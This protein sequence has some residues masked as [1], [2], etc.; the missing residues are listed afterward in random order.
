VEAQELRYLPLQQPG[1]ASVAID[2][3]KQVAYI[4][5]LGK[6]GDG[7]TITISSNGMEVGLFDYLEQQEVKRLIVICSHPHSDHV[8]G[9]EAAFSSSETFIRADGTARFDQIDVIDDGISLNNRL[10][11][12][13]KNAL[14]LHSQIKVNHSSAHLRNALSGIS[15][16]SDDIFIETIPYEA[17]PNAGTHG[18][19][20]VTRIVLGGKQSVVDFDDADS[21]VIGKV[22]AQ[23]KKDKITKIDAFVV[24]HH[25][26]AYHDISPIME[27][28][29]AIAI[30]AVNPANKYGHPAAPILRAL[31]GKLKLENVI[32][33]GSDGYV[34]IGPNGVRHSEHTAA[35]PES[36]A[37][38]VDPSR[39]RAERMG[40]TKDLLDYIYIQT[41]MMKGEDPPF[42]GASSNP[43]TPSGPGPEGTVNGTG[44]GS[45]RPPDSPKG[46]A[47]PPV[48]GAGPAQPKPLPVAQS[49]LK[50]AA[51]KK[52]RSNGTAMSEEFDVGDIAAGGIRPGALKD[53]KLFGLPAA[54]LESPLTVW[55]S[56]DDDERG[57]SSTGLPQSEAIEIRDHLLLK[58]IDPTADQPVNVVVTTASGAPNEAEPPRQIR[59]RTIKASSLPGHSVSKHLPSGGMVYLTGGKLFATGDATE[60]FGGSLD[61]CGNVP[62]VIFPKIGSPS[63]DLPFPTGQVF[64]EVWDRVH[65]KG[66]DTFYL[67]INP[68]KMFLKNPDTVRVPSEQLRYGTSP[69]PLAPNEVVT[70][71]DIQNTQ[72]GRILWESDVAFKSASMGFDVFKGR[73]G[74]TID[75][76]T[77]LTRQDDASEGDLSTDQQDRWCRLYWESGTLDMSTDP[78]TKKV[79]FSGKAVTARAQPMIL[80]DGEL[81]DYEKGGWCGE[82]KHLAKSLE[83]HANS[84]D[85]TMLTLSE[86]RQLA[87][88][89]TFVR[90]ARDNALPQTDRFKAAIA[91]RL[92]A[93]SSFAIPVWTSGIQSNVPVMAQKQTNRATNTYLLHVSVSSRSTIDSC[94][95][96]AWQL[97]ETEL[98]KIG[99]KVSS[100]PN[101]PYRKVE[102][103]PAGS[104]SQ[105]TNTGAAIFLGVVAGMAAA[106]GLDP[107]SQL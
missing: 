21:D 2:H 70:A 13:L 43:E 81:Q 23:L 19:S 36:Y 10:D 77:S 31:M 86:L 32:F 17:A 88:M 11:S 46:P 3:K 39:R 5:D 102:M 90:W 50:D 30:I 85:N 104:F 97:Q 62:C 67:S 106:L 84:L 56:R 27:L 35:D 66:I 80:K 96:P 8:G 79:V 14:A 41:V 16:P 40:K 45:P 64:A 38:F 99:L 69:D 1:Q 61:I 33:T 29:P 94:V 107:L 20:V 53:Q 22:V 98:P 9:I 42:E 73:N 87:L 100:F 95:E 91:S 89:Q 6:A 82:A 55:V 57:G 47:S 51:A 63:F 72:I 68:T 65:E 52:I 49:A 18:R 60:L 54:S 48:N 24:P 74:Q 78:V 34:E 92:K 103:V 7:N 71:G 59:T 75:R 83:D 12:A 37:L 25:G 93:S 101:R 28:D 15:L 76:R 44:D 58:G 4:V 26:S 105:T